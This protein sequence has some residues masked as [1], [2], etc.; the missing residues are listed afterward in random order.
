M[1]VAFYI[2]KHGDWFDKAIAF[3]TQSKYSHVELVLDNKNLCYSASNRSN[4]VRLA[5]LDLSHFD[6]FEIDET[7]VKFDDVYKRIDTTIGKK[8]DWVGIFFHQFLP[9]KTQ[10]KKKFWCSEAVGYVLGIHGYQLN[11]QEL[12]EEMKFQ[13]FIDG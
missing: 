11:P 4:S 3:W 5:H 9:F 13:G 7:M 8:Y 6:V 10:D 2:A 1:K 12:F